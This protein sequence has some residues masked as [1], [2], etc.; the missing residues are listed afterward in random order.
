MTVVTSRSAW[1]ALG[2]HRQ[3]GGARIFTM[4]V[5][6]IGPERFDP[7]LVLH[8]FPTS[9]FD[10]AAVVDGL[11][12]GRRVLLLDMLGYGLSAKPDRPYTMALQADLAAA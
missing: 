5:P 10:Y 8:G 2:T 7:L 9:S 12:A 6:S 1:E 11:R 3:L 4:D